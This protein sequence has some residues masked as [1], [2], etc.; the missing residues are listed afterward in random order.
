MSKQLKKQQHTNIIWEPDSKVPPSHAAL[1]ACR[2][3]GAGAPP[4]HHRHHLRI[5]AIIQSNSSDVQRLH[6]SFPSLSGTHPLDRLG[7]P[8][9]QRLSC[10]G[11]VTVTAAGSHGALFSLALGLFPSAEW[12]AA[13]NIWCQPRG[14]DVRTAGV[15]WRCFTSHQVEPIKPLGR[16]LSGSSHLPAAQRFSSWTNPKLS[17]LGSIVVAARDP[18][19]SFIKF[20]LEIVKRRKEV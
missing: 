14:P 7:V 13:F 16:K 18:C 2:V 12:G 4:H 3:S 19:W 8:P 20:L 9:D 15:S 5:N 6:S 17:C 11:S 1:R 10:S